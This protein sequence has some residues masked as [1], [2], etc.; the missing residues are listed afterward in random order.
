M[1]AVRAHE[2]TIDG[3][4]YAVS[5]QAIVQLYGA[6][7]EAKSGVRKVLYVRSGQRYDILFIGPE[8]EIAISTTQDVL[9]VLGVESSDIVPLDDR[10]SN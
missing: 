7:M 9:R 3:R 8:S 5:A 4:T 10:D 1:T 2:I 6:V